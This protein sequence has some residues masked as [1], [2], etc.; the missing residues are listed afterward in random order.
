LR[1]AIVSDIHGNRTAFEA[2]LADLKQTAPDL[3]FH[4]GDLA[5]GGSSPV[6]IVDHIRELGWPGVAGNTDDLLSMPETF[7]SFASLTPQLHSLWTAI[8]EMAAV[9]RERLGDDRLLWLRE[10]PRTHVEDSFALMHASPGDAWR[11]PGAD[12]TDDE[13][14]LVYGECA[15]PMVVYGHIHVPYIRHLSGMT[16]ANSG[17]VGLPYD[18]DARASYLLLDDF[19][20][21]IRR[22]EYALDREIKALCGCGLPHS[23]WVASILRSG[24]PEL[25]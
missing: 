15:L 5:D 10:L 13:L 14:Q 1:I 6:E 11:S 19:M 9:T 17:S 16:I 3:V 25:P 7:E 8:R 20:P 2:V 21:S 4:G 12:A 22:V 23:E 24:R 18:G